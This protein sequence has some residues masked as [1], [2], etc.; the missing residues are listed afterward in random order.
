MLDVTSLTGRHLTAGNWIEGG[1]IFRSNPATGEDADF[2]SGGATEVDHAVKAAEE[3][4]RIY[5]WAARD[6]RAAFLESIADEIEALCYQNLPK[7]LL[8]DDLKS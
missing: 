4:F 5:G 1:D 8:P 3:A 2:H 7:A 6:A